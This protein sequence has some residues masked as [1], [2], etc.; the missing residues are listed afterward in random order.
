[1]NVVLHRVRRSAVAGAC[2]ATLVCVGCG[3]D[4]VVGIQGDP[5]AGEPIANEVAE[6]SCSRCHTLSAAG[7]EG[8]VAPDLDEL[9]P[10][11]QRVLD[12]IRSGPGAMPSYD[13]E[14]DEQQLRDLA[15]FVSG[16]AAR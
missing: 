5:V 4:D 12:A 6:P 3:G 1:M 9:R 8:E 13:G 2:A 10:G 7:W 16:A 11:Y 15:A 14:L